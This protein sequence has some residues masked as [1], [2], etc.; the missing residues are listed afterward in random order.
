MSTLM[1]LLAAGVVFILVVYLGYLVVLRREEAAKR[2]S[3]ALV[4]G[5]ASNDV[6]TAIAA[7]K[8]VEAH[9]GRFVDAPVSGSVGPASRGELVA[10]VGG[11]K[12]AMAQRAIFKQ[13]VRELSA[14]NDAELADLGIHRSMIVALAYEAAYGK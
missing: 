12:K 14:L 7:A 4:R 9:G 5:Y 2:H 3:L 13:T 11:V 8:R 10:L 1:A 6:H